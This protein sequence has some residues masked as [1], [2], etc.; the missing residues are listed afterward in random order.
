MIMKNNLSKVVITGGAGFIGSNL[1]KKLLSQG[2][3]NI[4]VIDDLSTGKI[5]NIKSYLDTNKVNLVD[6]RVE[7]CDNLDSLLDLSLIHI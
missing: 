7:D 5:E 3:E 6:K 1:I 2:A 4:C